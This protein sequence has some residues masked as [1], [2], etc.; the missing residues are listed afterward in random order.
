MPDIELAR[1]AD[2]LRRLRLTK[3]QERVD[4]LLQEASQQ[5]LTYAAFLDRCLAEEV[6]SK[7][8][9]QVAMHTAM[10]RFPYVKTLEAFD[11]SFQ[12]SIDKKKIHELA[13]GRFIEHAE[14]LIL[15][16][17]PGTGKTHLAVALALK[18]VHRGIRTYFA[19]ATTLLT[20][21]TKAYAENRLE[22]KLKFYVIPRLL[23]IDE[24]G[25]VPID[26]H[27]AHLF[28]QLI[29]RRYE[30]GA[31]ILTSNRGFGQWGEIFGDP[32]IAT[33]SLDRLLHH[34]MTIN[35]KGES[36]R[37][38]EKQKAGVLKQPVAPA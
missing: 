3:L 16:G 5:D 33:A 13:T 20:A 19:A 10:A 1:I 11:F 35:I 15:L 4:T 12:P 9:R 25:Y 17:P 18:A 22:D 14:N 38:K 32:I 29:S 6:A 37:L 30:R 2:S 8:E 21:L 7:V 24:I 31:M 34:S 27:A 23:V 26:R 28:F 36:Y